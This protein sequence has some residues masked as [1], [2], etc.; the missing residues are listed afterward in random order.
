MR[1]PNATVS[2]L[3]RKPP[4]HKGFLSVCFVFKKE[5]K[6][7]KTIMI[8]ERFS[9]RTY[10]HHDYTSTCQESI[11]TSPWPVADTSLASVE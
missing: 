3:N 8:A 11:G 2:G 4:F 9:N 5:E 1:G 6:G 10:H 7:M